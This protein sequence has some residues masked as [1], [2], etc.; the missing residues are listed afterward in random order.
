MSGGRQAWS[1]AYFFLTES[2]FLNRR[3]STIGPRL[4]GSGLRY[5]FEIFLSTPTGVSCAAERM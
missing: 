1:P 4:R 5:F 2:L 3:I